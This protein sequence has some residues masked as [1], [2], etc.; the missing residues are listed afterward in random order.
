MRCRLNNIRKNKNIV[1]LHV[2]HFSV[3]VNETPCKQPNNIL[4]LTIKPSTYAQVIETHCKQ[5]IN[6]LILTICSCVFI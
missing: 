1:T 2:K 6:I 4:I 5:A 3:Q